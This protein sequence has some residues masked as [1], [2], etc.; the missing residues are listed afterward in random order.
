MVLTML[1]T[2]GIDNTALDVTLKDEQRY[3]VS[4]RTK[5][6]QLLNNVNAVT[7]LFNHSLNTLRL[8]FNLPHPH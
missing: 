7:V 6:C 1:L 5:G 4:R 3:L 8:S 2:D